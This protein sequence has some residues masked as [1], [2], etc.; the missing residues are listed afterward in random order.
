MLLRGVV[1]SYDFYGRTGVV[2]VSGTLVSAKNYILPGEQPS[3]N[4]INPFLVA[5]EKNTITPSHT[6]DQG[7][8][9]VLSD[10]GLGEIVILGKISSAPRIVTQA[11]EEDIYA[12]GKFVID[13]NIVTDING[14]FL[15]PKFANRAFVRKVHIIKNTGGEF[16][17]KVFNNQ[18]ELQAAW[19]DG[20]VVLEDE[21]IDNAG[22]FF[23]SYNFAATLKLEPAG[24]YEIYFVG[25][26]F[27]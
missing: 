18:N 9:V 22:F 3:P 13:K 8:Q 7:D 2:E 4:I 24:A 14:E 12:L 20:E 21:L 15:L 23:E 27:A 5:A 11:V 6:F 26:R 19:G 16:T 17:V 1:L 10:S 25:E